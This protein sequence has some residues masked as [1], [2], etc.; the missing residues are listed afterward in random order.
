MEAEDRRKKK[1]EQKQMRYSEK[2]LKVIGNCG[3]LVCSVLAF[4]MDH[5]N[6]LKLKG[7]RVLHCYHFGSENLK[8]SPNKVGLVEA[9]EYFL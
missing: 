6:N 4:D 7:V 8:G 5:I 2:R 3:V 1:S 9:V